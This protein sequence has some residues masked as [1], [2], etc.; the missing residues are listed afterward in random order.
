MCLEEHFWGNLCV[1]EHLLPGNS[2][3]LASLFI[4]YENQVRK[5]VFGIQLDFYFILTY[6]FLK[7]M[8]IFFAAIKSIRTFDVMKMIFGFQV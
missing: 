5:D 8:K 4:L 3:L 7:N 2:I 1:D 6:I